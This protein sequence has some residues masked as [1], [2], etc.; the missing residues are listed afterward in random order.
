MQENEFITDIKNANCLL[1]FRGFLILF[2]VIYGQAPIYIKD[3][4]VSSLGYTYTYVN[5]VFAIMALQDTQFFKS[6]FRGYSYK[7][8]LPTRCC[9]LIELNLCNDI[10]ISNKNVFQLV[11]IIKLLKYFRSSTLSFV[12]FYNELIACTDCVKNHNS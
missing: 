2:Q 8:D 11:F 12:Y 1:F 5:C 9:M 4:C 7:G 6:E 3:Q 10:R